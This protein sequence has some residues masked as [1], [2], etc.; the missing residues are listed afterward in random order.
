MKATGVDVGIVHKVKFKVEMKEYS[1][2]VKTL[3]GSFEFKILCP[4]KVLESELTTPISFTNTYDAA[5][6][7]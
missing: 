3:E 4:D 5:D 1:R 6:P 2:I 7:S